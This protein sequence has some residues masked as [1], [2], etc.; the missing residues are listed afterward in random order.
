VDAARLRRDVDIAAVWSD[1][2][3][4]HHAMFFVRARP[5]GMNATRIAVS[6]P[7]SL[8]GAVQ[9]NRARRRLREAFGAAVRELDGRTGCDVVVVARAPASNTPYPDLREAASASMRTLT[10]RV[11]AA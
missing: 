9:R 2:A 6:A 10:A 4:L 3:K 7:G 11:G 8:G 5:N 1:G